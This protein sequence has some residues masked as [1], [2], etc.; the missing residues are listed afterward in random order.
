[1][2]RVLASCDGAPVRVAAL[3]RTV[4]IPVLGRIDLLERCVKSLPDVETLIIIDNGDDFG[5]NGAA[6][7]DWLGDAR[8]WSMPSPMSVASSWNL[9]IKASPHSS[10]WLLLNSDAWMQG[11]AWDRLCS[12]SATDRITLAGQPGWCCAHIGCEVVERVGLFCE[13]FHPAYMEDVDYQR[14]ATILGI[15]VVHSDAAVGHDNSST[16]A[17]N[18][19]RFA[20]N[21]QTHAANIRYY[22]ERWSGGKLP[23]DAEWS[24]RVRL[25]QSWE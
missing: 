2:G 4:I 3:I 10:G 19:E 14:R 9:G 22:D 25:D 1:M 13:R 8:V 23:A 17:S 15:A 21:Q 7:P 20:K 18:P 12:Q 5:P 6:L 24:L 16:I 11:D